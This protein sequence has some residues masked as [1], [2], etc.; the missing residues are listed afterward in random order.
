MSSFQPYFFKN[1]F[2]PAFFLLSFQDS[3]TPILNP[4]AIS[5][6]SPRFCCFILPVIFSHCY[7]DW[8]ISFVP[9]SSSLN[10]LPFH[11]AIDP[12]NWAFYYGF[13]CLLFFLLWVIKFPVSY[14]YILFHYWAYF[15]RPS[16][17][18]FGSSLFLKAFYND[19]FKSLI[20]LTL[21]SF[22]YCHFLSL[23]IEFE[24]L[25]VLNMLSTIWLKHGYFYIM[26]WD[27]G[28][29]S[30]SWRKYSLNSV[31]FCNFQKFRTHN[32]I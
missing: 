1:S 20:I 32:V 15:L 6:S 4:V 31:V 29:F 23:F 28:F 21:V 7:S 10:F 12:I 8:I 9:C 13:V 22:L 5:H 25:L 11:S 30:F 14:L 3:V 24:I 2:S 17:F 19:C 16:I 27:F 26:L 18:S